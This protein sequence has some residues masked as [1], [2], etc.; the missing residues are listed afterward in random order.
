MDELRKRVR[1]ELLTSL[2]SSRTLPVQG[3]RPLILI[4][5]RHTLIAVVSGPQYRRVPYNVRR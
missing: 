5:K 3:L 1:T 2:E 4:P